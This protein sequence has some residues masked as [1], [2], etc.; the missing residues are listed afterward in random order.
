LRAEILHA[1]SLNPCH[2]RS[3][4]VFLNFALGLRY[5]GFFTARLVSLQNGR[6][7]QVGSIWQCCLGIL[8]NEH[9]LKLF[10]TG[11]GKNTISQPFDKISKIPLVQGSSCLVCK[12]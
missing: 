6:D 11:L 12:I 3:P 8:N 7:L 1:D 2:K 9:L 4:P 5:E 10:L